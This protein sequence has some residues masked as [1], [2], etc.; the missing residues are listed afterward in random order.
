MAIFPGATFEKLDVAWTQENQVLYSV[1]GSG[2]EGTIIIMFD[3]FRPELLQ[4]SKEVEDLELAAAYVDLADVEDKHALQTMWVRWVVNRPIGVQ[5]L[6]KMFGDKFTKG[7]T[8]TDY[9]PY[10]YWEKRGVTA[11]LTDDE[12]SALLIEYEYTP[13]EK[14]QREE[15]LKRQ[16]QGN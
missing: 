1:T 12:K 6:V 9:R 10:R 15:Q 4:W 3:D 11:Y 14:R 7:Y 13:E 2:I 16:R 8:T 5:R